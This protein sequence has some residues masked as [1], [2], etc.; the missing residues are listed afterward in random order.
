MVPPTVYLTLKDSVE[1]VHEGDGREVDGE[2]R[3]LPR[4]GVDEGEGGDAGE[5]DH[6]ANLKWD[7]SSRNLYVFF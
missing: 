1:D 7:F 6:L 5:H 2:E 4:V 3:L